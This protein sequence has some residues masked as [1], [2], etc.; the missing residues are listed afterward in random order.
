M[1]FSYLPGGAV[2][3]RVLTVSRGTSKPCP[4]DAQMAPAAASLQYTLLSRFTCACM[5]VLVYIRRPY[6]RTYILTYLHACIFTHT[7]MHTRMHA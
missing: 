4:I 1:V 6:V 3:M 5:R 7:H 2:C